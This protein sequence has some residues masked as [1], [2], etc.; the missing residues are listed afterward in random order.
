MKGVGVA[1][2]KGNLEG[3]EEMFDPILTLG[4]NDI[5]KQHNRIGGNWSVDF[6]VFSRKQRDALRN[7][8]GKNLV[9][10]VLNMTKEHQEKRI[11]ARHGKTIDAITNMYALYEQAGDDEEN[12]HNIT[13]TEDMSPEEVVQKILEI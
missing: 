8:L 6:A 12:T 2:G 11:I 3:V 13:I 1:L 4:A 5:L 9:F 7:I 10:V